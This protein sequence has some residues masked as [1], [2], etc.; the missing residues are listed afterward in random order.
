MPLKKIFFFTVSLFYTQLFAQ[1]SKSQSILRGFVTEQNTGKRIEGVFVSASSSNQ[2]KSK[3]DGEFILTFQEMNPGASVYVKIRSENWELVNEKEMF[4]HIPEKAYEK[5]FSIIVCKQGL[6]QKAKQR[7]YNTLDSNLQIQLAKQVKINKGNQKKIDSLY[8]SYA[9]LQKQLNDFA[10]YFV[11]IDLS[12]ATEKEKKA[13]Q[14]FAEGK[15]DEFIKLKISLLN[16]VE[17]IRA[18]RNKKEAESVI[19]NVDS[20]LNFYIK[21][22][23]EIAKAYTLQF[24]FKEADTEYKNI[25]KYD[26]LNFYSNCEY[27]YF[28]LQQ[29]KFDESLAFH[30]SSLKCTP[31]EENKVI[32]LNRI[33]LLY[34]EKNEIRNSLN[35]YEQALIKSKQLLNLDTLNYEI[36]LGMTYGNLGNLYSKINQVDSSLIFQL[37]ALE[38]YEKQSKIRR[39]FYFQDLAKVYNNLGNLYQ[40][41]GDFSLAFDNYNKAGAIYENIYKSDTVNPDLATLKYNLGRFYVKSLNY[42]DAINNFKFSLNIY[43]QLAIKN[44]QFY[45][46]NVAMVANRM[47]GVYQIKLNFDSALFFHN[48]ALTTYKRLAEVYPEVYSQNLAETY[49]NLGLSF[50]GKYDYSSTLIYLEKAAIIYENF[51]KNNPEIFDEKIANIYNNIG[52]ANLYI[53]EYSNA[54]EFYNKAYLI[55]GKL[56]ELNPTKYGL[57]YANTI[58]NLGLAAENFNEY[59]TALR[60]Y[61]E[62]LILFEKLSE[63]QPKFYDIYKGMMLFNIGHTYNKQKV[64]NLSLLNLNKAI[65]IYE[66]ATLSDNTFSIF[67]SSIYGSLAWNYL[68]MKDFSSSEKAALEAINPTRFEKPYDYDKKIEWVNTNLALAL[69]YQGKY[70]E[71]EK[72]YTNLKDK[73]YKDAT[74]RETFLNDLDELEKAGITHPDVAKIRELLKKMK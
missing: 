1:E 65:I 8:S 10:D 72:I 28:L 39:G 4:T 19:K 26:S 74:Y 24:K 18:L 35:S 60:Y 9:E 36:D 69:L 6:L 2:I 38:I 5:P 68:F 49:N 7:Y 62:A 17:L 59:E 53:K 29:N 56:W 71:A 51:S 63:K 44:P 48:R 70:N 40:D 45:E 58:S 16:D 50:L 43:E 32:I 41:I 64:Y 57:V 22:H 73:P 30:Q 14:L 37:N 66:K 55:Y 13:Y 67:L 34:S 52:L 21:N 3:S 42:T 25:L 23:L 54:L 11:R 31:N 47:G 46:P 61:N 15:Y 33:G 27:A 20:V 12:Y